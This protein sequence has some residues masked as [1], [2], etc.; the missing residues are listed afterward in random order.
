MCG[1]IGIASKNQSLAELSDTVKKGAAIL[2]HRGP[3]NSSHH[4][5]DSICMAHARLSILDTSELGNQ[6]FH[7]D[8]FVLSYNG[9]IYNYQELYRNFLSNKTDLKSTS[10]TEVLFLLLTRLGVS[11]T[12]KMLHGMF[13]FSF[14]SSEEKT[15]YLCRDKLGIK[16][17]YWTKK[18][19]ELFW[20]SEVKALREMTT[21]E[22]D[23][24]RA[25]YSAISA[26]EM[27]NHNSLFKDVVQV[28]PGCYL[29]Y[30]LGEKPEIIKY[31]DLTDDVDEDYYSE[32]NRLNFDQMRDHLTDLLSNSIQSMLMSDVP[33]GSFVSGGLDSSII[34]VIAKEFNS[35]LR[36]FSSDVGGKHSE[37]QFAKQIAKEISSDISISEFNLQNLIDD[38]AGITFHY[39]TPVITHPNS[40]P[41]AKLAGLASS[42]GV[43]PVLTG[44][45]SDELFFGYPHTIFQNFKKKLL[46]P[47]EM[48]RKM[49]FMLPRIGKQL[50]PTD[51]R[52]MLHGIMETDVKISRDNAR[53]AFDFL[54]T[55]LVDNQVTVMHFLRYHLHGLLHRNDRMGMKHSIESR[56]PFLDE[57]VVKFGINLPHKWKVKYSLNYHDSY[58]PFI[59]DKYILR[60]KAAEVMSKK[61]A[62]RAK[63]G[64]PTKG[65]TDTTIDRR[66]FDG[67]YIEEIARIDRNGKD[68]LF[69]LN[70]QFFGKLVLIDIFGRLF[71]FNQS[72]EY[73]KGHLNKYLSSSNNN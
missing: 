3:D 45:G 18:G 29:K 14:Y 60:A 4:I 30:K 63:R 71:H 36:L 39:E 49:Y 33:V 24:V 62:Y 8:R 47:N 66:F 20:A 53:R 21:I 26:P 34:T 46:I 41:F 7:T 61:L 5:M 19:D 51:T 72:P 54:P 56:F 9:E 12:I 2:E 52:A 44:E 31:Y 23:H 65:I 6:P 70:K 43:K 37:V 69:K 10:D 22:V 55:K 68:Q 32:L 28:P 1:I 73:V 58:H 15:L 57:K 35:G 59:V 40:L 16:P 64:F 13:A 11:K 42:A 17:L 38:L 50:F 48:L 67:G 27:T 25:M